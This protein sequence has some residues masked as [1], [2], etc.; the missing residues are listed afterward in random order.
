MKTAFSFCAA[1]AAALLVTAAALAQ[2]QAFKLP[3]RCSVTAPAGGMDHAAMGHA[4][5]ADTAPTAPA[6]DAATDF[7]AMPAHVQENMRRAMVSMAAMHE[8]LMIEDADVAF[9]CGMIAHHQGAI[10]MAEVLLA[11]GTD[12]EL[13]TLAET[14]IAAQTEEIG[15]MT[16]WLAGKADQAE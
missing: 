12:P 1:T 13:R 14:I 10:D 5:G 4:T 15:Q 9:A 3:D 6:E 8:G 16:D 11:H 2:E 7:S